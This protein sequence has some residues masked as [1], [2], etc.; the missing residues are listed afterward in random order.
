MYGHCAGTALAVAVARRTERRGR[1]P[2]AVYLGGALPSTAPEAELE[3]V[4]GRSADDLYAYMKAL[5]G[6]DGVLDE[7]DLRTVLDVLRHD[8]TQGL[9]FQ[10]ETERNGPPLLE[11]PLVVVIGDE[12]AAT[13]GYAH[14]Y[15]GWKRYAAHV[16]LAEI[17]GGDHYFVTHR[18][19]ALA[20]VITDRLSAHRRPGGPH[21]ER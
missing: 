9:R 10:I 16:E 8:M 21:E 5:G 11:A 15:A 14:A 19:R 6:F 3:H 12:D 13:P 1:R 18:P 7:A 20:A 17:P 4:L 2:E